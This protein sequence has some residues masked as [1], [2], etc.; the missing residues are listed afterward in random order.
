MITSEAEGKIDYP[1][2]FN[3]LVLIGGNSNSEL[4]KRISH[5]LDIPLANSIIS[6]F[7]DGEIRVKILENVRGKEVFIIQS[8]CPPVNDNLMELLI[9]IDAIKRASA[10]SITAII[11]YFGYAKQEKK[12]SGREPITAKLV[13][14][15]ITV[16]GANR[17]VTIDLHA[18]AIQGFFDI[19][20]DNLYAYSTLVNAFFE[21]IGKVDKDSFVILAPDAGSVIRA[22]MYSE[23]MGLPIAVM[24]KRRPDIE[25]VESMEVV[26]EIENKNVIIVDD[27]ISTAKTLVRAAEKLKN[28]G[29]NK[30][31]AMAIHPVFSSNAVQLID[32]SPIEKIFVT[33]TIP[34]KKTNQKIVV[35]SIS[36]LISEVIKRI[37]LKKSISELFD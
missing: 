36:N 16:A 29:A 23:K 24:F 28:M 35:A 27:M 9:I 12:V 26:G 15:L 4:S 14:N 3:R 13:A 20:V 10:S 37:Y 1:S 11:P 22:R 33:D 21:N 7:S 2:L 6:K 25:E 8:T 31:Y 19:P 34:V 18:P 30:I 17:V 5:N 32:D